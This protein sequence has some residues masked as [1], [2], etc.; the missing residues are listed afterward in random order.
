MSQYIYDLLKD[1]SDIVM[2]CEYN[3]RFKKWEP[4]KRTL[5]RIHHINDLDIL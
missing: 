4:I 5:Q 2:E 1:D 3:D